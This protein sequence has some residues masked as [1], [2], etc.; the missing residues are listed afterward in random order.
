MFGSGSVFG[1]PSRIQKAPEYGSESTTLVTHNR[2]ESQ[3]QHLYSSTYLGSMKLSL[4]NSIV[5]G[6][7]PPHNHVY[8]ECWVPY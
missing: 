3:K 4:D 1:I 6:D 5:P 8:S 2:P 7:P